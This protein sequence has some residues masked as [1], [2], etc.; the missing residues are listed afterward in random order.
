MVRWRNQSAGDPC[1]RLQ[2]HRVRA[3]VSGVG[4]GVLQIF[5]WSGEFVWMKR[6]STDVYSLYGLS[7]F[8]NA[9]VI[10][11][12]AAMTDTFVTLLLTACEFFDGA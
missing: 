3:G 2:Y 12:L 1:M 6:L 7:I 5:Q 9:S 8:V 10:H 4:V 11:I